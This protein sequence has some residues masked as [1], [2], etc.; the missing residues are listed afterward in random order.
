MG[1]Q[2]QRQGPD[3][4]AIEQALAN[5][6]TATA[7]AIQQQQQVIQKMMQNMSLFQH[8]TPNSPANQILNEQHQKQ[9]SDSTKMRLSDNQ[10]DL[11][12]PDLGGIL[13]KQNVLQ[14]EGQ[15]FSRQHVETS[16]SEQQQHTAFSLGLSSPV[17]KAH[18]TENSS[19]PQQS[20][21]VSGMIGAPLTSLSNPNHG[22]MPNVGYDPIKS[23][24]TQLQQSDQPSSTA[25]PGNISDE[26]SISGPSTNQQMG[27]RGNETHRSIEDQPEP[28]PLN[29][30]IPTDSPHMGRSIWDMPAATV[31]APLT[32]NSAPSREQQDNQ[33]LHHRQPQHIMQQQPAETEKGRIQGWD[34]ARA[35]LM[36]DQQQKTLQEYEHNAEHSGQNYNTPPSLGSAQ[37][38]TQEFE[39]TPIIE[40]QGISM[41]TDSFRQ[42]DLPDTEVKNDFNGNNST[43]KMKDN[44]KEKKEKS[45]RDTRRNEKSITTNNNQQEFC[46]SDNYIPGMEGAIKPD[47][48]ITATKSIEEEQ[49][50]AQADALYRLQLEQQQML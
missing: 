48:P 27:Y 14:T 39:N 5:Q 43:P 49:Q 36:E 9:L 38:N 50:R 47:V 25:Q 3:K 11:H 40:N 45:K 2:Q 42:D 32:S 33:I 37:H 15:Q 1:I 26:N 23:L 17:L 18:L 34:Q 6:A 4:A 41:T 7:Q 12:G 22:G 20:T 24:L 29:G 30:A 28:S 10:N 44:R 21:A 13:H 16:Q 46:T 8:Q 19:R 35:G 31:A